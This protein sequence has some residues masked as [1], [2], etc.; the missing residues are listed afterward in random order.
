MAGFHFLTYPVDRHAYVQ[1]VHRSVKP[2]GYVIDATFAEDGPL[3]CSGVPVMRYN[4]ED[5][6]AEFGAPFTL[7]RH[8]QETHH[9]PFGSMQKFIYCYCRKENA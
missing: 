9:T 4:A 3:Q 2:G 7:L 1:A 8:E 6:H 5:L